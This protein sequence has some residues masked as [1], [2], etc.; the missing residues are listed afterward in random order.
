MTFPICPTFGLPCYP[1]AKFAHEV[2]LGM[3]RWSRSSPDHEAWA[4]PDAH[5]WHV[6]MTPPPRRRW[7][8]PW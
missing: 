4:C 8:W 5:H 6:R 7:W 1:T 2:A 3:R